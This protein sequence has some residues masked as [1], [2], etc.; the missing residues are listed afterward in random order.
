M[1]GG[2]WNGTLIAPGQVWIIEQADGLPL[3]PADS[4]LLCAANVVLYDRLLEPLVSEVLPIG[5]YA[6][7]MSRPSTAADATWSPRALGF[8]RDGWNVLVLVPARK[9][10]PPVR[11]VNSRV[12]EKVRPVTRRSPLLQER[13][14]SLLLTA[15]GLAG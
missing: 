8:A 14:A 2:R 7:P 9:R 5:A 11:L 13:M 1:D 15:N 12:D 4:E 6:E 3:S 10:K